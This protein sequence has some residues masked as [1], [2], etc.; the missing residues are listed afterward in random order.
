MRIH[1]CTINGGGEATLFRLA[2]SLQRLVPEL[3]TFENWT[4]TIAS[5][6]PS[7]SSEYFLRN[8]KQRFGEEKF[9][10]LLYPRNLGTVWATNDL[11]DFTKR[12]GDFDIFWMIDD[13]IELLKTDF[14]NIMAQPILAG[15]KK[16]TCDIA[17]IFSQSRTELLNMAKHIIVPDHGSGC[18]M[19]AR[20]IF[21]KVG[22]H[23]EDIIQ[24]SHD[25]EFNTRIKKA[26][27]PE[28]LTV[29]TGQGT[30]C[31]HYN[32]T[33]T[34]QNFNN[35]MPFNIVVGRDSK[36]V[37]I[38]KEKAYLERKIFKKPMFTSN[39]TLII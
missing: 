6:G 29:Y 15:E 4:W 24:Y 17:C 12:K 39:A 30:L 8:L 16:T 18:T 33:G 25:T 31:N 32:Q 5:Q 26:Y 23:D 27:G 11:I 3:N 1:I 21:E 20:D 37:A 22:Y 14:I 9:N 13:D 10:A 35:I 19:Y 38:P 28:V 7:G 34:R 2:N 36:Y